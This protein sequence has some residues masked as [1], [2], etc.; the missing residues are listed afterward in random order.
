MA[1]PLKNAFQASDLNKKLLFTLAMVLAYRF[2]AQVSLP[3]I[4]TEA[5]QNII[6][7]GLLSFLDLFSGGA[8]SKVAVFS[9]GIMPYITASIIMSLLTTV[10]PKLEEWSKEGETGQ[11]HISQWTR[12]FTLFLTTL[13]SVAL[14]LFLDRTSPPVLANTSILLKFIIVLSLITGT[15]LVMWIGELVTQFGIGNGM[16]LL[17]FISIIARLPV[18]TIQSFQVASSA[19]IIISVFI[20]LFV[21]VGIVIIETGQRRVPVQYAK[22]MVGRKMYGGSSTYVPLKINQAGVIPIIFASSLLFFPVILAQGFIPQKY[23]GFLDVLARTSSPVNIIIYILLIV[24]FTYFYTAIT[25]NPIN[26]ADQ[27]RKYGGFIPGIRPGKPTAQY[28]AKVLSRITLPGSIFLAFIAVLPNILLGIMN[29]PFFQQFAGI[30]IL[31]IVGVALETMRQIQ[32][33]LI[34]RDYEGFLQK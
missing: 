32:A 1:N 17:I 19:L 2:G 25:F 20:L 13:Q 30:S 16:S 15:M 12:I 6:A 28:L 7:T 18:A 33:Q 31:I 11:K 3:G 14:V 27:L 22:R 8:L 4:K 24:F 5:L 34:M 26:Y 9:L 10:V 29:V 23:Q 21:T